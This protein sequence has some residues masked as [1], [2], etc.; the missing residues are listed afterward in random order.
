MRTRLLLLLSL[1]LFVLPGCIMPRA[2][3]EAD[4][5][6]KLG[7]AYIHDRNDPAAISELKRSVKRNRWDEEAWQLLGLAYF[8][9]ER[10]DEAEV[11]LLRALRMKPEFAQ[12]QVNLGS[13]YLATERFPEAVAILEKAVDN[14]EYRE[15]AR[16]KHNLAYAWFAQGE[17]GKAR[18]LYVSVLRAFPQ[19]CPGLHGLGTVDEAEGK[20]TD[21]MARY[22]EALACDP[23][24]LKVHLNL[25]SVEARLDLV[26][27]ACQH[28]T[29]VKDADPYGQ[30]KVDAEMLLDRLDCSTV[31]SL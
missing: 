14:A 1:T 28:L 16:A 31:G 11:A 7:L 20:L 10:Y 23:R 18:E 24:D 27:D 4:S 8:S 3:A 6:K 26:A 13:L 5:W 21:A 22:K 9:A 2:V 15:P 17:Y 12:A 25:G 29:T 19:F 30:F